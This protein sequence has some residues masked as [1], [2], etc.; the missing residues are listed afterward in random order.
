VTRLTNRR[1][2]YVIPA[3]SFVSFSFLALSGSSGIRAQEPQAQPTVLQ[4]IASFEIPGNRTCAVWDFQATNLGLYFLT[5]TTSGYSEIVRTDHVGV[6]Q[7]I[8]PIAESEIQY[9]SN[10]FRVDRFGNIVIHQTSRKAVRLVF[11]DAL[12]TVTKQVVL[13]HPITDLA[14]TG[15]LLAGFDQKNSALL[16]EPD[17]KLIFRLPREISPSTMMVGLP[18]RRLA[19]LEADIPR[20][21][22]ID[23]G[24]GQELLRQLSAPEILS[25]PNPSSLPG[26]TFLNLLFTPAVDANG[27]LFCAASGYSRKT[28]AIILQFD[29]EGNLKASY[30]C[31]FPVLA[32]GKTVADLVSR[33]GVAG[34]KLFIVSSVARNCAIYSINSGITN[35]P[36]GLEKRPLHHFREVLAG[37][38]P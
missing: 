37:L 24:T 15:E 7:N 9:R 8:T 14:F 18:E 3:I 36:A 4:P 10:S 28:G 31:M 11:L 22:T 23:L 38:R 1:G 29:R 2:S 20:V 35:L 21:R 5:A 13:T 19:L 16:A 33:I 34:A 17:E 26:N 6:L 27:D 12:G 30:R 25:R 32:D